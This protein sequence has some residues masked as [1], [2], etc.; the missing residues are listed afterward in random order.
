MEL[1]VATTVKAT[2]FFL[3]IF[4]QN[5]I[6]KILVPFIL[7]FLRNASFALKTFLLTF[8]FFSLLFLL[9]PVS[10]LLFLRCAFW[11]Y[12]CF[13]LMLA[14]IAACSGGRV[15]PSWQWAFTEGHGSLFHDI[16]VSISNHSDIPHSPPSPSLPPHHLLLHPDS[17]P[18]SWQQ[19]IIVQIY[20]V[21]SAKWVTLIL[22]RRADLLCFLSF[23]F[24]FRALRTTP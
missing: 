23:F 7:Y 13:L 16:T 5:S 24:L 6:N 20:S 4:L 18:S 3:P 21:H 10:Y 9:L 15:I 8:P 17:R 12:F 22:L 14:S 2:I 11:F 1:R 19:G